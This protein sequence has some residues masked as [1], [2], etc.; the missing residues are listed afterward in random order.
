MYDFV[1]KAIENG[2]NIM[3]EEWVDAVWE[4]SLIC[5]IVAT[6]T[7]FDKYKC[8]PFYKLEITTS[9]LEGKDREKLIT[10]ID[11][12]GNINYKLLNLNNLEIF[13][14]H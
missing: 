7:K 8:P 10:L 1:Q 6:E 12:N 11:A 14:N 2:I 4:E 5:N 13:S 9:G 3:T